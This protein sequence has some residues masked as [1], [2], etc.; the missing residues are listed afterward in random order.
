MSLL[1]V[2]ALGLVAGVVSGV[3]GTGSSIMLVPVLA[4]VYGPKEAVPIMAVAAVMANTSRILAWTREIDWR[5]VL[6]YAST[7]IPAAV[8]GARTMLSLSP[9]L[10]DTAIGTFLL[11]MIPARHWLAA[12]LLRLGFTHLVL[13]G[14]LIGFLTGIVASTGPVSVPVF[15]GYG[16]TKGAFIGTEAAGSLAIYVAKTLTFGDAGA[17]PPEHLL[18]GLIVGSSLMAG[19]FLAKPFVLRLSPETFRFV[20][21]GLLLTSGVSLLWT[22]LVGPSPS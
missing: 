22:G 6:A 4:Y 9:R 16:L 2:L 14:A 1:L 13:A 5:A 3:I 15:V 11:L 12:R 18:K 7:G 8:V 21:D 20:M 19:A 10:V 17:L